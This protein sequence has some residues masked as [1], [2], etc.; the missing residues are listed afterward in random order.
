MSGATGRHQ[1]QDDTVQASG[2]EMERE[3]YLWQEECLNRWLANKGRGMV[4]AVTGSGKTLMALEGARRLEKI[5]DRELMVRIVVPTGALMLQ[6]QKKLRE[7]LSQSEEKGADGQSGTAPGQIGLRGGGHKGTCRCKYMIYVI[8]SARYELA[9]QILEELQRG[10][11]VFLIADECHHYE[12]GEN[13]LIFEFLPYIEPYKDYFF[14]MG[15]SATL[16]GGQ[17]WIYLSSVLGKRIYSY[18]FHEASAMDTI[19]SYDVYHI[20]LSFQREERDQYEDI[21][22]RMTA[23]YRNL[24]RNNPSLKKAGIKQR[25]ELLRALVSD[26]DKKTAR[27][28]ALYMNLTYKRKSL[29]CLASARILCACDLIDR[30]A[31]GKKII[32][33]G[34]RISQ[35]EEL[36]QALDSRYPGR[37]GRYHSKMGEQANRNIMERFQAGGVRILIACKAVDEGV[38]VSDVSVGIILSGTSAQRQRVQ[39][40]GRIIRK[41]A[42]KTGAALYYLHIGETMEDTCFLPEGTQDHLFEIEYFSEQREFYNPPY[43]RRARQLLE[44]V[45]DAGMP[46]ENVEEII[47]CLRLGCV[48]SDWTRSACFLEEQIQK[49]CNRKDRNYWVCMKMLHR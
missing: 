33:F 23:V 15:L 27:E 6:W 35:A 16:P 21:S 30:L 17:A 7:F 43:D 28:A 32:I 48:R 18:G 1:E 45:K 31:P 10:K 14:S 8:N 34:E 25:Y 4:Q 9:R 41:T 47:R 3:L 44:D 11:A 26:K 20:K 49:A 40:L 22:S 13:R 36:Y 42:G 38:D 46:E 24:V 2:E 12:S 39:R 5:T 19:C 37:V 29:V